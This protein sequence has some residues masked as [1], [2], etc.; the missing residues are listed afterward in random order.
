MRLLEEKKESIKKS[1]N[2]FA[3]KISSVVI[4]AMV[5]FI[6]DYF[7]VPNP[8]IICLIGVVFSVFAGGYLYGITSGILTFIYCAYFFSDNHSFIHYGNENEYKILVIILALIAMIFMVGTL[9]MRLETRTKELEKANQKLLEASTTDELTG[10]FNYRH[11]KY[12]IEKEWKRS[13]RN[14]TNLSI[15]MID[16]DF[17]KKYNDYY[18]HQKGNE[19]LMRVAE[20]IR[21]QL[22]RASDFAVRYGGEEFVIILPETDKHGIQ[23]VAEKIRTAIID[24]KIEHIKSELLPLLTVSIGATS[25]IPENGVSHEIMIEN[26]DAALYQAKI[27]GKNMVWTHGN[28]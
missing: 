14:K 21:Q 13:F 4:T 5:I 3:F 7:N 24:S 16:I 1:K 26:A 20:I 22:D 6:V 15:A 17:F 10:L 8:A 2:Q 27:N 23:K 19:C 18:G 12:T 28:T 25:M 9:K 11:F